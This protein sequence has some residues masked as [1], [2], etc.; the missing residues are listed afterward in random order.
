MH[1]VHSEVILQEARHP[2]PAAVSWCILRVAPRKHKSS[3]GKSAPKILLR[4]LGHFG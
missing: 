2:P 4:L 3:E 1:C